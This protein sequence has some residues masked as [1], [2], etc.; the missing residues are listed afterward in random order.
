MY[1]K[2]MW[3]RGD[4]K[5]NS[6]ITDSSINYCRRF[7]LSYQTVDQCTL[8]QIKVSRLAEFLQCAKEELNEASTTRLT[9]DCRCFESEIKVQDL[10]ISIFQNLIT[11]YI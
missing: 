9:L 6:I 10:R 1:M 4:E 2:D 7:I 5:L 3:N 11:L 8:E